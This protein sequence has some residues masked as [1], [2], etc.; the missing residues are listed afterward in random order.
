MGL[1][2]SSKASAALELAEGAIE[3][4]LE[5]DVQR[6]VGIQLPSWFAFWIGNRVTKGLP[7]IFDTI[8]I[9]RLL[10]GE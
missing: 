1:K 3:R 6:W 9:Y 7:N 5:F 10:V 4:M 2:V 8:S